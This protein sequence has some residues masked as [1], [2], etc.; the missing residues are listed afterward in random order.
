M[1]FSPT[2]LALTLIA[3]SAVS[4]AAYAQNLTPVGSTPPDSTAR[5]DSPGAQPPPHA[6]HNTPHTTLRQQFTAANKTGDGHLTYA[7]AKAGMPYVA[8]H[9][10]AIDKDKK[11]YVTYDDIVS[12]DHSKSHRHH[13]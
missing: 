4:G 2:L 7:Q 11:G 13:S 6:K 3:G 8:R 9:F 10:K 12:Y 1:R 5:Q